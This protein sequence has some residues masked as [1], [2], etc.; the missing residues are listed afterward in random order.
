[1]HLRDLLT[2]EGDRLIE[3]ASGSARTATTLVQDLGRERQEFGVLQGKMETSVV[4]ISDSITRHAKMVSEA[5]DLAQS[6]IHE[7]EAALAARAADLA[8]AAGE[9]SEAARMAGDDL[10][11]Q[12]ARL[13]QAGTT[14]TEQVQIV[15]EGLSQ[16]RAAL[17]TMAHGMRAEQEDLAVHFESHRAQMAELLRQTEQGSLQVSEVAQLAGETLRE[18]ITNTA[19]QLRELSDQAQVERRP[20]PSNGAPWRTTRGGPSSS[21]PPAPRPRTRRPNRPAP[22]PG[23]RSRPCRKPPS[24]PAPRP[25]PTS[26]SG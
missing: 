5:S 17:V 4:E 12:A 1:M 6:Q 18:M 24:W 2:L 16:Q 10:S 22:P 9:A 23:S 20:P 13:E 21:S 26:S 19:D 3:M 15:E 14:V 8:A 11:R 25:T 7:A